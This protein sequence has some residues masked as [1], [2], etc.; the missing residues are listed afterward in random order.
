MYSV[1][2]YPA[3]LSSLIS[4]GLNTV[5]VG[6]KP[7]TCCAANFL[8]S[9]S[10]L[11]PSPGSIT[12]EKRLVVEDLEAKRLLTVIDVVAPPP[13]HRVLKA[14]TDANSVRKYSNETSST[15]VHGEMAKVKSSNEQKSATTTT[16]YLVPFFLFL[17]YMTKRPEPTTRSNT[18]Q[19]P[20]SAQ[21]T[22]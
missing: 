2:R 12:L 14:F 11:Q 15:M 16:K 8:N 3:K 21:S 6:M 13:N 4:S 1:F 22:R 9:S 17:Y 5:P 7:G 10:S 18:G 19:S 20:L